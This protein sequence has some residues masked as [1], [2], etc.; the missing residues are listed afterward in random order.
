MTISFKLQNA[1][2]FIT[3]LDNRNY[4]AMA[5]TMAPDFTHRFLPAT[6]HG[7]GMPVRSKEEFIQH[8]KNLEPVF[9]RLNVRCIF[10]N[11]L[12]FSLT[13]VL[14]FFSTNLL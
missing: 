4:G 11:F 13:L 7:F 9:E 5:A 6:L 1:F 8:V 2:D 12:Y 10:C 14:R 3:H